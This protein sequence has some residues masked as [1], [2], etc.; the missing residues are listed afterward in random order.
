MDDKKIEVAGDK[1][2]TA[3]RDINFVFKNI[4]KLPSLLGKILPA[5]V[6]KINSYDDSKEPPRMPYEIEEK[7]NF[8]RITLYKQ[9]I[10]E[11]H[12]YGHVLDQIYESLDESQP[13]SK[14]VIFRYLAQ[15]YLGVKAECSDS[16]REKSDLIFKRTIDGISNDIR[17]CG[18]ENIS[19]EEL[20][21]SASVVVC[22]GFINC[23]V[24]ENVPNDR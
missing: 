9:M 6:R 21:I 24:M 14:R 18:L 12:I 17:D 20:V 8:N 1:N 2:V 19:M 7:I 5:L 23:K 15:K 22:H 10:E 11:Y 13:T 16:E 4:N 3:G